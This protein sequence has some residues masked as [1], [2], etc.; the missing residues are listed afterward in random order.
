[1]RQALG[2]CLAQSSASSVDIGFC[3]LTAQSSGSVERQGAYGC[4][5]DASVANLT[6][7][8]GT[9]DP[10]PRSEGLEPRGRSV[11]Y[12]CEAPPEWGILRGHALPVLLAG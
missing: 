3:S 12:G 9:Y 6:L 5:P 11:T 8:G 1:M 2:T 10:T 4:L 7:G